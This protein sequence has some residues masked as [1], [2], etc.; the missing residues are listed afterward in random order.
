[1]MKLLMK[2]GLVTDLAR[3]VHNLDLSSP[4][5]PTTVNAALKPLETLSRA[6]NT[7]SAQSPSKTKAGGD[8]GGPIVQEETSCDADV[9]AAP[10]QPSRLGKAASTL[11]HY[12]VL[13]FIVLITFVSFTHK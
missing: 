7:P 4:Y 9:P 5:L 1:M 10:D 12:Q 2:K 11:S 13:I 6:V 3:I 8:G